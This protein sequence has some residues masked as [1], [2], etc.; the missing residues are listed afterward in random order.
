MLSK[1]NERPEIS[2]SARSRI[3]LWQA[4]VPHASRSE[5]YRVRHASSF[6][7]LQ[8]SFRGHL[9]LD[10]TLFRMSTSDPK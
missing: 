10:F 9:T 7:P 5:R 8:R 1:N 2:L 3:K 6:G 4:G